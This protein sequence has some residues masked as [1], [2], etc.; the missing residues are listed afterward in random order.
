M[1]TNSMYIASGAAKNII[2]GLDPGVHQFFPLT[3]HTKR[4]LE[5]EGP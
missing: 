1:T 3:I 4:G 2:E 5:V